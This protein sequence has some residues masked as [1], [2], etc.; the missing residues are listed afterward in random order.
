MATSNAIAVALFNAAAGAYS[1]QIAADPTSMANAAGLILQKDISSDAL[2]VEHLLVNFGVAPSNPIYLEAKNALTGLVQ[3]QGRGQAAVVAID[4]LKSQEAAANPYALVALNFAVKVAAATM[5]S[6]NN[7]NERDV[8]KLVSGVTGVDTDQVAISEA[9]AAVNPAFSA[10]LQA[11]LAAADAKAQADK[12]AAVAAQ[13]ALSDASA[14]A[15]SDK[16]TADLKAAQDKA[17]ADAAAAKAALDKVVADDAAALKAANALAAEAA[18]KAAADK[19]AAAAA[20][21][22]TT[23]NAAAITAFLKATA[24]TLGL[25]GYESM[26]DLQLVNIIKYSDNQAIAAAVDKTTDNPAAITAFLK[27]TASDLGVSG[28]ASMSNPQLITAIRTVNDTAV[29]AAQKAIDD[30]VAKAAADKAL[31]DAAALKVITDAAAAQAVVDR[32]NAVAAQKAADDAA[33]AALKLITDAAAAKAAADL[34]TALTQIQTLQN[35]TGRTQALSVGNDTI[36]A[37]SGG[38]DT[39]TAT[40]LTYGTDDLV[41]DTSLI[42][43]DVLT[44][45]T[46][47]DISASPVV[48]GFENVNVNVTSVYGGVTGPTVLSFNA[49]N[50]RNGT[51]NFDVT[52]VSSVV[53]GLVVTN[54]PLGVPVTSTN[55][56]TSVNIGADD[57]A[58]VNYTGYATTLQIDSPGTLGDVNATVNATTAGTIT[59]DSN[60]TVTVV[61]A[62]DTNVTAAAATT[63]TVTS[64][65]QAT[66]S[67]NAATRV[68]VTAT[69]EA[70]VTAN[71]ATV[72]SFVSGDGIDTVSASVIDSTLTSTN[73]N[74]ITVNVAGR[75]SATVLDISGAPNVNTV[76]V[77]GTQNVTLKVNLVGI[78]GL[79]TATTGT[80]ADDNLLVVTNANSGTTTLWVK[81]TGGDA[82]FSQAN[83]NSIV[84]GA[85][86]GVSDD[87]TVASNALIVTAAD[88]ANDVDIIAKN[89]SGTTNTVR[90]AVQD[91]GAAGVDGDL[92]GGL[93]LTTFATATLTNNDANAQAALGPVN[94]SGTALTIAAGTQGF[95]ESSTINLG[96]AILSVTGSGAVDLG[97][98]VTAS[99]VLG[100]SALGAITLGL[101]GLGTV[102]TV[103]TGLGND[104]LT[105]SSANRT[106]GA[107]TLVT[108]AGTDALTVSIAQDFSWNAG[109]DYDTLKVVGDLNL[110]AKTISLTSVDEILL[111]STGTGAKTLTLNA[112][113]FNTNNVF[114]LRG[115]GTGAAADLLLVQGTDGNDTLNASAVA[116]EVNTASLKIVGGAG[117]DTLTGSS[118][119]DVIDGGAGNDTL[120]GGSYGDTYIFNSGDCDSGDTIIESANGIG[121]DTV[122]VATTTDFRSM[123][124]SSFDEIEAITLA[125]NQTAK[126]TGLQLTGESIVL[127]ADSGNEYVEVY[128]EPGEQFVSGLSNSPANIEGLTYFGNTGAET[129]TGGAMNEIIKGGAGN[130]LLAGGGGTD[131]YKFETAS[132]NGIDRITFGVVDGSSVDDKLNFSA[133]TIMGAGTPKIGVITQTTLTSVAASNSAGDNILIMQNAYF[134][135]AAALSTITAMFAT[136]FNA[137]GKVLIVYAQSNTTDARVAVANITD[138]GAVT[139][140]TDVAI[141]VG[142]TIGEAVSGFASTNF[143]F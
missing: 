83:V 91:N 113:T 127:T 3:T 135:D 125:I 40:N 133:E 30:G 51:L 17:I 104:V 142:L 21:D 47:D 119:P 59:T 123:T 120:V 112:A 81:T 65:G 22:K 128:V 56:F 126:F 89:S 6:S 62:A 27:S 46:A 90:I 24:A 45:S 12:A 44:L 32:T 53:T 9:L 103:T 94:A 61:A 75:T 20:V 118:G 92:T 143:T 23:D 68:N 78:D 141:L 34:Q 124:T 29:A 43:M 10:S 31:A 15:A 70:L 95:A 86:M 132:T 57:R 110:N 121:T 54:L 49:D 122:Y 58:V 82:D 42:D 60:A 52:N 116:V 16:A 36:L 28:T 14:K 111:D 105:M 98:A 33:A 74:T 35:V 97:S 108:G 73:T 69:E 137:D 25:T 134:A 19:A 96:T 106:S 64:E 50:L 55:K 13:K 139:S 107:Y 85:G 130:D 11:A 39:V 26:T 102:G 129:I 67:A 2:Y 80:T 117:N 109:A 131:I 1:G 63:V 84:L 8:T 37:V 48:V 72:V 18:V 79:G 71:N 38:N 101:T 140:A 41:V 115:N 5:Y 100:S 114:N 77:T 87:L 7:P 88:Q 99:S 93:T 136:S 4:F 138:A 66:I 76:N